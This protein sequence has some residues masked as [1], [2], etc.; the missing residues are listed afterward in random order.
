MRSAMRSGTVS[1]TQLMFS[2]ND[3]PAEEFVYANDLGAIINLDDIT[4]ID[5]LEKAIGKI[6]ETISCRSVSY[7]HLDVYKRQDTDGGQK[8]AHT[9][10]GGAQV[11]DLVDLQGCVDLVGVI[12]DLRHLVGGDGVQSAA[13]GVKLD[14]IQVLPGLYEVG[15]GVEPG[16]VHPLIH[17]I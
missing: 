2:S 10:P 5:F 15:R 8:G 17:Y 12:Q 11:V 9:D 3:T 13:E 6:P 1:Y 16:V 4:H 7:T 14:Q